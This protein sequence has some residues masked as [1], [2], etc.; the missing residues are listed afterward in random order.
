MAAGID[1]TGAEISFV[2][3]PL[4]NSLY[5]TDLT[6][7]AG[8][9]GI[10]IEHPLFVYWPATGGMCSDGTAGPCPDNIDRFF[11][12]KIDLQ[13]SMSGPIDGGTAAFTGFAPTNGSQLQITFKVVDIYR[14][15][16]GTGGTGGTTGGC[17]VLTGT[18]SF[19][20][21]VVPVMN[22]ALA[23]EGNKC[24]GC[25]LQ[26]QNQNAISAM[27]ITGIGSTDTS[28]G[29]AL[30]TACNQ[31]LTRINM[32]DIPN[33]GVILAPET[34]QDAAH[35]FKFANAANFTNFKTALSNWAGAEKVA[36]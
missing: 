31:V 4:S 22:V 19:Q 26:G 8:T 10:Y 17:K 28:P 13:A 20:S 3:Q 9:N 5:L 1:L 30:N 16:S 6:L 35:P 29:G 21:L 14:A 12:T 24:A 18:N 27:D 11:A 33:S 36:P 7:V 32:Q 34:G 15:D 25:H 2:V 23:G